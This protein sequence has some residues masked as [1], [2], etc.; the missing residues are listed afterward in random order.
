MPAYRFLRVEVGIQLNIS[1]Q[2]TLGLCLATADKDDVCGI[3]VGGGVS[4]VLGI[5]LNSHS[6]DA[7]MPCKLSCHLL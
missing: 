7:Q 6:Q 5:E 2:S 3:M 4:G 1:R